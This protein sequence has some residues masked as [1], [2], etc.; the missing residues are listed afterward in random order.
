MRR[1][2]NALFKILFYNAANYHILDR[3]YNLSMIS[4]FRKCMDTVS[5]S[6]R[7]KM[8]LNSFFSEGTRWSRD[9]FV[10]GKSPYRYVTKSHNINYRFH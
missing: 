3:N 6:N 8:N 7:T 9:I 10:E 2:G 5:R 1:F 4:M